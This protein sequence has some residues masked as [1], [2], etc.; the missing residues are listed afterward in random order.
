MRVRVCLDV[1]KPLKKDKKVRKPGGEWLMAKCCY[2]RLPTFYYV[3]GRLGHIERHSPFYY[4]LAAHEIVRSWDAELRAEYRR[5]V[6]LGGEQWIFSGRGGTS[7]NRVALSQL[8]SNNLMERWFVPSNV[9]AIF[10]NLGVGGGLQ[11]MER[12]AE[13]QENLDEMEGIEVG[14]DRKKRRHSNIEVVKINKCHGSKNV[15]LAGP[16][17]G[18]CPP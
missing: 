1:T 2:K 10:G 13:E 12:N 6:V 5:P 16:V 3:C 8:S 15:V 17:T 9:Q 4:H 7:S 18:S 11:E 14:E